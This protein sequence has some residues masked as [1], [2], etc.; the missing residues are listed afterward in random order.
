MHELVDTHCHLYDAPLGEAVPGVLERARAAR[1]TCI[2]VPAYDRAS[3]QA[4]RR[5][6]EDHGDV[7]PALGIHPW[8]ATEG[9]AIEELEE[10]LR[11]SGAVAVG[12]IGLDA[13]V[14]VP[15]SQQIGVLRAQLRLARRL[16]LPV[17]LHVRGDFEEMLRILADEPQPIRGV[18][19]AFSRGPDLAARFVALGLHVAFGGAVTRERSRAR[20]AAGKVPAERLLLETDAP[21]I[22]LEGVP[23]EQ[24][25]PRH[26]RAIAEEVARIRGTTCEE[27]AAITTSNA[28]GLFGI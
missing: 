24:T 25:E 2:V 28:R 16:G 17:I 13:K 20:V 10:A 7:R 26:V 23:A 18:V 27:I 12:E 9:V 22:G 3:W 8:V 5:L 21:S 15:V 11:R 6:A 1:V 4:V 14:E 19:H